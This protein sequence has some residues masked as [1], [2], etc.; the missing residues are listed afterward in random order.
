MLNL[1]FYPVEPVA[2]SAKGGATA[3]SKTRG[4]REASTR[5]PGAK[6]VE[7]DGGAHKYLLDIH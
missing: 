6:A 1:F 5:A 3:A 7:A 4:R 2:R